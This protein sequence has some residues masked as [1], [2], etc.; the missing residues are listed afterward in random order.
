M[1]INKEILHRLLYISFTTHNSFASPKHYIAPQISKPEFED[2][3]AEF[4][5]MVLQS[6]TVEVVMNTL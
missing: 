1:N 4:M 6:V 5:M 3:I 2:N